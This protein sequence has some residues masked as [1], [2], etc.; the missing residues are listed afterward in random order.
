MTVW[1]VITLMA[2]V[3]LVLGIVQIAMIHQIGVLHIRLSPIRA[4][5]QDNDIPPGQ[6]LKLHHPQWEE[7]RSQ[8]VSRIIVGFISPTCMMCTKLLPAFNATARS[9]LEDDERLVLV[10]DTDDRR[11]QEYKKAKRIVS[12]IMGIEDALTIN[13]IPGAPYMAVTG[14]DGQVLAAGVV[15]SGEQID[16][17]IARARNGRMTA[18]GDEHR[19]T[20]IDEHSSVERRSALTSRQQ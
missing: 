6:A 20:G 19:P 16:W 3:I 15:N 11:A 10:S 4:L 13:Q 7:V 2:I 9:V 18:E 12:P 14:S 1:I 5:Q 8:N 17:L